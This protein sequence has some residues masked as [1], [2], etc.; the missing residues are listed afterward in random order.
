MSRHV[1]PSAQARPEH[2]ESEHLPWIEVH[3]E[4]HC[5]ICACWC[6]P[7]TAAATVPP[8]RPCAVLLGTDTYSA[9]AAA[10]GALRGPK[11]GG[12]NLMVN[13]Q[14]KDILKHVENPGTTVRSI[15]AASCAE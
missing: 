11:H 10:I 13:R 3:H 9:I 5:W 6:T 2:G 4:A 7:T 12:A 14:L 15:C 8:Y 1:L